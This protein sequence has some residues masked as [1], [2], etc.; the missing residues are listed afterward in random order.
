MALDTSDGKKVIRRYRKRWKVSTIKYEHSVLS[1]LAERGCPAPRLTKTADAKSLVT[2]NG[3][4]F[5]LFDFASGKNYSSTYLRRS[6]RLVLIGQAAKALANLHHCL[7][8]Y[9]PVGQHHLGFK[10]LTGGSVRDMGWYQEKITELSAKSKNLFTTGDGA[11]LSWLIDNS[12]DLIEVLSCLDG[13]LS[14][15]DLP[16]V[17]IHGDFGLH[18]VLFSQS[19]EVIPLDFELARIEWRLTDFLISFLRYRKKGGEFDFELI[20]RFV[21]SY[22]SQFPISQEEWML[23]PKVWQYNLLQFSIQ[24]WNS[25]FETKR[26]P[27]R[28]RL[29]KRAIQ[30]SDWG[31]SQAGKLAQIIN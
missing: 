29:A 19:G 28:L 30:Q 26:N 18:N 20:D 13:E 15:Q 27:K 24:Y 21:R 22:A 11:I 23:F 9:V 17:V 25:Y 1:E 10:G 31:I 16:R 3:E 5:S 6:D 4:N 14:D 7:M 12:N 2:I 8:G